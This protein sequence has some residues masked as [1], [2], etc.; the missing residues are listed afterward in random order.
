LQSNEPPVGSKPW[1]G[2]D[3]LEALTGAEARPNIVLLMADD[4]GYGDT[5]F[6]GHEII[7]TPSLDQM[8]ADGVVMTNFHAGAPVCSPTRGTALTGRHAFRY[9]IYSANRGHLRPGEITI[10]ELLTEQGYATGHFGK[11]HLGTLSKTM[12]SK[13]EKR[14]PEENY[15]PP[16]WHGYER[17]FVTESA[18]ATWNPSQGGRA[19]DNPF[20]DDGVAVDPD[21]PSLSGG[22]GRVVMDRA[23]P[24]IRQ[25]V[26]DGRPFFAVVWFH[27]PHEPIVAGPEYLAMYEGHGEAAHYYG[28]I[29][30]MDEQIGRLRVELESLGVADNTFITFTSD[31][32]PEGKEAKGKK[33][34]TTGGLRGR[35]RS[36]YEGGVRVPTVTVWPKVVGPGT[37][38]DVPTSTL[39]YLPTVLDMLN[40]EMPDDRPIDGVSLI[41]LLSGTA[42]TR[43]EPIPFWHKNRMTLIDGE[44]K[45]VI[46]PDKPEGDELY[47]LGSD[48]GEASDIVADYPDI[49]AEMRARLEAFEASARS[50]DEGEDY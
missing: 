27:A 43:A 7:Q 17:S 23:I 31:N 18:V 1:A 46:T 33:A 50:S 20:W 40:I 39:D 28:A 10:P 24:F 26:A 25:A 42:N 49:A 12:S 2:R 14:A 16:A 47:D 35:K 37:V 3:R 30:E 45:L 15:S 21:D 8:A 29:T 11:W 22:A 4:L 41:P 9:G 36:L 44:L 6:N 32:G 19:N 48:R 13:G 5:G 34:G 38:T